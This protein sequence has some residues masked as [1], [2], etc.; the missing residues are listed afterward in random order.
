MCAYVA[1]RIML[2]FACICFILL[3]IPWK[4]VLPQVCQVQTRDTVM[5]GFQTKVV[6]LEGVTRKFKLLYR[7]DVRQFFRQL[8]SK[9]ANVCCFCQLDV[10]QILKYLLP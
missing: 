4:Q 3:V 5:Q 9:N 6:E 10:T 8:L 7:R 1:F 2:H